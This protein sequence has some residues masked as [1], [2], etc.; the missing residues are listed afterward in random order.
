MVDE[1]ALGCQTTREIENEFVTTVTKR[2]LADKIVAHFY[3]HTHT[4]TFR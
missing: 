1:G 3:G 4:D 2:K